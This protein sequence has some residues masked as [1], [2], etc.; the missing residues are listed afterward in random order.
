[1]LLRGQQLLADAASDQCEHPDYRGG[2]RAGIRRAAGG[3]CPVCRRN[4]LVAVAIRG[5]QRD[6]QSPS[7]SQ[8]AVASTGE[9]ASRGDRRAGAQIPAGVSRRPFDDDPS[10]VA[11]VAHE[12]PGDGMAAAPSVRVCV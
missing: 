9:E 3:F 5:L 12:G 2:N 4:V 8:A 6:H 11:L 10:P 7:E 1:M